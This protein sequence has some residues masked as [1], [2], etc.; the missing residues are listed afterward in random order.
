[1]RRAGATCFLG[2]T[3]EFRLIVRLIQARGKF[4]SLNAIRDE[5]WQESDT[6]KN[7]IQRTVSSLRRKLRDDK[8]VG[9]TIEGKHRG[10]YR[11][12]ETET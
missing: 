1:M 11:L 12:I 7:T 2:P 8:I 9:I 4:V 3:L 10:H 6:E 5:V